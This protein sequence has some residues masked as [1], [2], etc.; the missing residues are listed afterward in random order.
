MYYTYFLHG[1]KETV[2]VSFLRGFV[3]VSVGLA[4]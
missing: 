2:A 1:L 3:S 4:L